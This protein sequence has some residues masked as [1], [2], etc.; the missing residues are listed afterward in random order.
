MSVVDL[1]LHSLHLSCLGLTYYTIHL[2][3]A[4]GQNYAYFVQERSASSDG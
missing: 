2:K 4:G 3:V 1:S